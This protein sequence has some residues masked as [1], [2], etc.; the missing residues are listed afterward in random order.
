[1]SLTVKGVSNAPQGSRALLEQ[2]QGKYGFIPNL[3]GV[4]GNSP[5]ALQA[6]TDLSSAV[7]STT[8]THEERQLLLVAIS[9]ENSCEYC[10]A[11]HST[12]AGMVNASQEA[13]A[14]VREQRPIEAAPRLEALRT[15]AVAVVR[16]RGRLDSAEVESFLGSGFT[17]ENILEVITLV[18]LKTMS[19]YTNHIADTPLDEAFEPQ[20]WAVP[21]LP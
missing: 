8:F 3:F 10:V 15:F 9:A 2:A 18:A 7:D 4:L 12:I 6:Y 5:A 17:H 20:R 13:L 11:A 1:M 16:K 14:S 19:N 21:S